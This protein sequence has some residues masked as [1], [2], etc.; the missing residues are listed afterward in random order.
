MDSTVQLFSFLTSFLYGAL[1]YLLARFN[2]F[3]LKNHKE[4]FKL[5]INIVFVIDMVILYIYIMFKI[6]KGVIHIY[7]IIALILGFILMM[8]YFDKI[9]QFCKI[10]VKI[11]NN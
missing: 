5:F 2:K 6:N 4:I 7:F 8:S 1:F 9:K 3:I 11:K 10:H